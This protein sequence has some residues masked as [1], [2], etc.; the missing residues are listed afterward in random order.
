MPQTWAWIS[1]IGGKV[2]LAPLFGFSGDCANAAAAMKRDDTNRF[3]VFILRLAP[4]VWVDVSAKLMEF[5]LL[6]T[7]QNRLRAWRLNK[8]ARGGV[9][10]R[11]WCAQDCCQ[12][13]RLGRHPRG[14]PDS[15]RDG[16]RVSS[17]LF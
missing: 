3:K 6:W 4:C 9:W 10:S 8:V 1:P 13:C 11:L 7:S 2:A 5:S 16:A 14:F 15:A 12:R 17:D